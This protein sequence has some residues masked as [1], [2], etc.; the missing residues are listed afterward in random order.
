M[1]NT[2]AT[3]EAVALVPDLPDLS[4]GLHVNFTN[5]AERLSTSTTHAWR[6]RSCT[7]SSTASRFS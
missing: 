7:G 1:V 3:E 4:I 5:E 6:A 2:P